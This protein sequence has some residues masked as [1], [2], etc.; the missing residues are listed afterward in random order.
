MNSFSSGYFDSGR[1][2]VRFLF[3]KDKGILC[4]HLGSVRWGTGRSR[5][6]IVAT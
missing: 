1:R 2:H 5:V 6:S 3:R 4:V